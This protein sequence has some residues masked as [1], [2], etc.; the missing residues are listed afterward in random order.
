MSEPTQIVSSP[1]YQDSTESMEI[2]RAA[3]CLEALGNPTRLAIF[4]LL[5][6]A[7]HEG[8]PVGTVQATLGIPGSTLS[9]HLSKLIRVGL[10]SQERRS[11]TLIC[12]AHFPRMHALIAYLTDQCCEGLDI[13]ACEAPRAMQGAHEES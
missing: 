11:R 4:R 6:R 8:A 13:V 9:H 2:E 5:V 12:R 10:V 3:G 1:D 7:G